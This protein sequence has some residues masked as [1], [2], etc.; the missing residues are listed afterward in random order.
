[1]ALLR[2]SIVGSSLVAGCVL[3]LGVAFPAAMRG[4]GASRPPQPGRI[5]AENLLWLVGDW[6]V[7]VWSRFH[8]QA[9]ERRHS[10][11]KVVADG[12]AVVEVCD[13]PGAEVLEVYRISEDG[14][15]VTSWHFGRNAVEPLVMRGT[16]VAGKPIALYSVEDGEVRDEITKKAD[17]FDLVS[18]FFGIHVDSERKFRSR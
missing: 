12:T 11:F 16:L 6:Q 15:T 8:S 1:M 9:V 17:G 14:K 10:S 13:T 7:E 18:F 3:L 2:R 4:E 5:T